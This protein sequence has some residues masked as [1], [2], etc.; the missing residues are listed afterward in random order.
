[1]D[2]SVCTGDGRAQLLE[3]EDVLVSRR[4]VDERR[5]AVRCGETCREPAGSDAP[6][7]YLWGRLVNTNEHLSNIVAIV[8]MNVKK[9][10]P[11]ASW[12]PTSF[13]DE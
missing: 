3:A 11:S 4:C 9:N 10:A 12:N 2:F 1:M 7:L 13:H 6:Q 5:R 8:P